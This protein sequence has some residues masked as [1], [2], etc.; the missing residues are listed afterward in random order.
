[1]W[2][3][4]H[5]PIRLLSYQGLGSQS[6]WIT[7]TIQMELVTIKISVSEWVRGSARQGTHSGTL[8]II[9]WD[10]SC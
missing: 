6:T 10:P 3:H 2:D 7:V 1:M 9:T 8:V 4:S 5:T